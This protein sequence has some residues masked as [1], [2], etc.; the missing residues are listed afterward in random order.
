MNT[1]PSEDTGL[2]SRQDEQIARQDWPAAALYVVATPIG[3][4]GDLSPR[5][6]HALQLANLIAAEDTRTS[7]PLLNHWD[8]ATPLMAAHQHNEAEAAERIVARLAAGERV[9]L[10]S[11]AG[12]PAVSDPG[13]RIVRAVRAAGYR[14]IPI[15]GASAVLAALM[16]SGATSDTQPAFAFA[17]FPPQRSQARQTW[18]RPWCELPAPVVLYEAPHRLAA[19]LNDL[20]AL[21]EP[22]RE[23]TI[24]RELTKRF[25]EIVCLPVGQASVWLQAHPQSLQGEFVLIVGAAPNPTD[26][27]KLHHHD[28][29]L[30]GLLAHMGVRDAAQLA[31]QA[32]GLPRKAL[33]QRALAL[34]AA[35]AAGPEPHPSN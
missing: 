3:N 23:L 13:A 19:T 34:Q 6:R 30:Q 33:Y 16:A 26:N 27:A 17:G 29:L 22:T 4:L 8:I 1:P 11:D 9:A 7:R 10:I 21:C 25:E 31:A 15:P 35:T 2:S 12:T 20:Q 28:A 14:V 5:A 32:T 18:L 24:A